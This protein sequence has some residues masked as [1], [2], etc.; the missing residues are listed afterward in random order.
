MVA[1]LALA[2]ALALERRRF[3]G[4]LCGRVVGADGKGSVGGGVV[5]GGGVIVVALGTKANPRVSL[6]IVR[7]RVA[8]E[9]L[10]CALA[11]TNLSH[12][13]SSTRIFSSIESIRSCLMRH[14]LQLEWE[15]G[16]YGVEPG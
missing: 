9:A 2:L 8:F 13:P 11:S 16:R 12:L 3:V 10:A 6:S 7:E 4:C 1:C 5:E 15:G 14:A